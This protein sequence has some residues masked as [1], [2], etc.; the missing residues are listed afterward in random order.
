MNA[1]DA[2]REAEIRALDLLDRPVP[3][4]LRRITRAA[5]VL[6]GARSA[7][8]NL[9]TSTSQH[10]LVDAEGS[11]ATIAAGDSFCAKLVREEERSHVVPD[12]RLDPRF[13][14]SPPARSG[15]VRSYAANQLVTS[16][17]VAI[18]TLCVFD[19]RL[20]EFDATTTESLAELAAAVV[21]VLEA[22]A[23]QQEMQASLSEMSSGHRELRRSNEHLASFAGQVAHDVQGPLTAVLMSLQMLEEDVPADTPDARPLLDSALSGAQR[24]RATIAGLM[25]FAVVGGTLRSSPLDLDALVRDVLSDLAPQVGRAKVVV[26]GLPSACGDPVQI[27]AVL[28]NV[29]ANALKYAGSVDRPEIRVAG[30]DDGERTAITVSDNGP[31]VPVAEREA[32]FA[33]GVR[34][35][36]A[37][38]DGADGLGIG[39]ATCRRIVQAHGGVIGVRDSATGGAEFWVELPSPTG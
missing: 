11:S 28:Q 14:D 3:D 8:I 37:T 24:M 22:Q 12:A 10:T 1:L 2:M 13:R 38:H 26:D 33:L 30:S 32:I 20:T 6:A 5:A 23:V 19:S 7:E 29:L 27:S 9:I 21:D 39:L 17:G 36:R 15:H 18:G 35:G 31:G 16:N 34:G 25:D 4:V